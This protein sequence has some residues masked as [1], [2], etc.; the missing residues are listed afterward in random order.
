[1]NM[2]GDPFESAEGGATPPPM[3]DVSADEAGSESTATLSALPMRWVQTVFSPEKVFGVLPDRPAWFGM[4]ASAALLVVL[5]IFV[6]PA[7][8]WED[9]NRQQMMER[10]Q[11]MPEGFEMSGDL[12]RYM[13]AAFG[14]IGWFLYN[15]VLA[16]YVMVAYTFVLGDEGRFKQYFAVVTHA[17]F[18]PALG[19]LILTPLK[20]MNE[21]P[22]FTLSIGT[23][24][25]PFMDGYFVNWMRT[26]D[27]FGLWAFALI[28]FG[29]TRIDPKR[30]FGSAYAVG[31]VFM[32]GIGA[33]FAI[34][35]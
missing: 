30:S 33:V 29:A 12:L 9:M 15:L 2:S 4:F 5:S 13:G 32:I 16:G 14:T 20:V 7:E 19:G 10:G 35:M 1:M 11:E 34:W 26:L 17:L 22:Q 28:A 31:L 24:L 27:L 23:F 21:D 8:I 25:M 18:I 3:D 6:V